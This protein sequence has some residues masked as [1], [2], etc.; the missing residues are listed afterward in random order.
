MKGKISEEGKAILDDTLDIKNNNRELINKVDKIKDRAYRLSNNT[1]YE[2]SIEAGRI[3]RD[4][5]R[6]KSLIIDSF[7]CPFKCCIIKKKESEEV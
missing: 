3:Y 5:L 7:V 1:D 6:L 2:E 4:L